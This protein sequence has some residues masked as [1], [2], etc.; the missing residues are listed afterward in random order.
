MPGALFARQP[1][2]DLHLDVI[3][4]ELLFRSQD[5]KR[6]GENSSAKSLNSQQLDFRRDA[7]QESPGVYI[8][9][10]EEANEACNKGENSSAKSL[11]GDAATS[12]LL[13]D[14][15]GHLHFPDVVGTKYAFVNFTANL[16]TQPLP[17]TLPRQ[18]IVIEIL[19]NIEPTPEIIAAISQLKRQGF[20]I[21]LDD[22][23]F[24][25]EFIPLL[26]LT[27]F[28]KIDVLNCN[29]QQIIEKI[30]PLKDFKVILIAEKVETHQQLEI[31]KKLGFQFFQGYFMCKPQ[32]IEGQRIDTNRQVALE[33][34]AKIQNP[35]ITFRELENIIACDAQLTYKIIK[36][37]NS[38]LFSPVKPI[39]SIKEALFRMGLEELRYW[40]ALIVLSSIESKPYELRNIAALRAKM[41]ENINKSNNNNNIAHSEFFLAGLFSLLDVMMHDSL[42]NILTHLS[43]NEEITKG[44]LYREGEI[45]RILTLVES[46]EKNCLPPLPSDE[47]ELLTKSYE[48][49]LSWLKQMSFVL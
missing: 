47:I 37:N 8:E 10:N 6:K 13:L 23:V 43:L 32:I 30:A 18:Q 38:T 7:S 17:S 29:E 42:Q 34:L 1:I 16:L 36:L 3:G 24:S 4:Y 2:F 12:T 11:D 27:K 35:N 28:V 41:C 14:L 9:V 22:F 20:T 5:T 21:A 33:I 48:K 31:C 44:L 15:L 25:E 40:V 39:K 46:Y 26:E 49:A 19:E 45:G